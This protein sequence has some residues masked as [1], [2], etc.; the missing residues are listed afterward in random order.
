MVQ[1]KNNVTSQVNGEGCICAGRK[2]DR[3]TAG[4]AC[5]VYRNVD[6]PGIDCLPVAR[7]PIGAYVKEAMG[8][9]MGCR[10]GSL[11]AHIA[12]CESGN[13]T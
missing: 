13:R 7:G 5:L 8:R 1:V 4:S 10:L 2:V 9:I 11:R 6:R 12:D 3:A